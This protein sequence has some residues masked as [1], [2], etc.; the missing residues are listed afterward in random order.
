VVHA[1]QPPA[2]FLLESP[3]DTEALEE[4]ARRLLEQTVEEL[5]NTVGVAVETRFVVGQAAG[6]LIES[7]EGADLLVVGS[8]GRGGFTSLL[9]G[10]TG[11]QCA[12]HASC[13]VMIVPSSHVSA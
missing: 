9:L 4:A 12:L 6:A 8:R 10:S 5:G 13:P 3:L 1:W 2:S 11:Q 7:A